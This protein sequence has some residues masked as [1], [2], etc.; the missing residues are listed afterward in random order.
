LR[1]AGAALLIGP[2]LYGAPKPAD[3]SS[4]VPAYLAA[5]F[6]MASLS[7]TLFFWLALGI[8]MGLFM[9]RFGKSP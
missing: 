6:V 5:E 1:A 4:D 2:Q 9:D 7:T 3:I 8:L